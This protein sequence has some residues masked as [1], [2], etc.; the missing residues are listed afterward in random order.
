MKKKIRLCAVLLASSMLCLSACTNKEDVPLVIVDSEDDVVSFNL[1]PVTYDD[2]TQVGKIDCTYVQTNSQEVSF[3]QTGKYVDKVYV[4]EGDKVKKG[5]LLCELSSDSLQKSID[6]LKYKIKRNELLLGYSETNQHLAEQDRWVSRLGNAYDSDENARED[7]TAI[8]QQYEREREL[9]NDS[10]EFDREELNKKQ[11]ELNSSRLYASMDGKVFKL[12]DNLEGSTSKAGTV[13]MTIV[14]DSNCLFS[15]T[16]IECK[17]LFKEGVAADMKIIYSSA[18]GDY[19]VM[20][21]EM[22]SWTDSMLFSIYDGPDNSEIEMGTMGTI[23]VEIA[24]KEHVLSVPK[25]TVHQAGDKAFVY[26]LT[27]DNVREIRYIETGLMGDERVEILSG[28]SEGEK[29]LKK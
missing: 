3:N 12:K 14:D 25:D 7:V 26:T 20:P 24:K 28:L 21:Y 16:N 19:L 22:D 18:A 9:I 10:L 1:I 8:A 11:R 29:V 17:D 27:E 13:I 4:K 5:T 6:E 15:S 23:S 2:V